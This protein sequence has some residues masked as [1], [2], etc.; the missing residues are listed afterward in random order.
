VICPDFDADFV[1]A[2][3]LCS[4]LLHCAGAGDADANHCCNRRDRHESVLVVLSPEVVGILR[5]TYLSH[6]KIG[7]FDVIL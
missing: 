5:D 6:N 7:S 4:G 3:R 2:I 1:L